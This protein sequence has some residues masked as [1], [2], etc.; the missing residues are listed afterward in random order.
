MSGHLEQGKQHEKERAQLASQRS[1]GTDRVSCSALCKPFSM[2]GLKGLMKQG[3][4]ISGVIYY[5]GEE[6]GLIRGCSTK[7]RTTFS[8]GWEELR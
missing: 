1:D 8:Q 6:A 3:I 7:E 2:Q 4:S 5:Q